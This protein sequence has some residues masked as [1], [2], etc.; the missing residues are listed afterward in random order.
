[1]GSAKLW[2]SEMRLDS[3]DAG[4]VTLCCVRSSD[5]GGLRSRFCRD[6]VCAV[7]AHR[8]N[9]SPGSVEVVLTPEGRP[10][11]ADGSISFS[12]SHTRGLSV[13]ALRKHGRIGVDIEF[14]DRDVDFE[15]I[16]KAFFLH[17]GPVTKADFF[18]EWTCNEA[19]VKATGQGLVFPADPVVPGSAGLALETIE[20]APS[21][22]VALAA[23][24][25]VTG[26][27]VGFV[28]RAEARVP[29]L[30]F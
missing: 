3:L 13:I 11:V 9:R 18:R 10:V 25:P 19:L 24:S 14:M 23:D 15:L 29:A 26:I 27:T 20:I 12:I 17:A 4:G 5:S 22:L 21:Y 2:G 6:L 1:M 30:P 28:G 16:S 8:T 7:S